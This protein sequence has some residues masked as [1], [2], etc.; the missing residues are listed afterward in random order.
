[1]SDHPERLLR[2]GKTTQTRSAPSDMSRTSYLVTLVITVVNSAFVSL[3]NAIAYVTDKV[4]TMVSQWDADHN[5]KLCT[6]SV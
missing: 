3:F 5:L 1:M 2:Q 6:N 4:H